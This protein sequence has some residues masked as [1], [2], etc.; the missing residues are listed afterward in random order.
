MIEFA[1]RNSPDV[2][3]AIQ[4]LVRF[5]TLVNPA[6]A[7]SFTESGGTG[8][9][10]H[11]FEGLG[12]HANE[13]TIA[14]LYLLCR[15]TTGEAWTP[16]AVWF[17]H[18]APEEVSELASLFGTERIRFG[19]DSNGL[20]IGREVL[21]APL[22]GADPALLRVLETEMERQ[23][24][25]PLSA[26]SSQI[27]AETERAV[28]MT[29]EL[30]APRIEK[31]AESLGRSVRTLQRRLDEEGTSFQDV[32]ERAREQSAREH[33]RRG[34]LSS[35]QMASVLG[36]ADV[37]SFLRAFKR[38]TGMS[39]REFRGGKRAAGAAPKSRSALR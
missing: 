17:A 3:T 35:K 20:L 32:V 34:E 33:A 10:S 25:P 5:A 29:L 22:A 15:Q 9:L 7:F 23:A 19:Q 6:V 37:P 16:D 12:R 1:C 2:R 14:L 27:V 31:I 18:A 38:W 28:K 30:G 39:P 4:Q 13:F 36:Y 8:V 26:T 21:D 24:P 11:R